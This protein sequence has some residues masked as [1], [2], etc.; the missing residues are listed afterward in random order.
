V[1]TP[2]LVD[3]NSIV[4]AAQGVDVH[5]DFVTVSRNEISVCHSGI[6]TMHGGRHVMIVNN[7]VDRAD[8]EG[9]YL[10]A[11]NA[12]HAEPA[13]EG[14]PAKPENTNHGCLVAKNIITDLGRG[15]EAWALWKPGVPGNSPVG[16][17]IAGISNGQLLRDDLV[18]SGNLIYDSGPDGLMED[19][20]V[21]FDR[22][23]HFKYAVWIEPEAAAQM[24]HLRFSGN[25]FPPGEL[26]VSNVE[27]NR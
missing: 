21:I 2:L 25:L 1:V 4:H 23:P 12:H 20:Q 27:L 26:G 7:L 13:R 14:K 3:G 11:G 17:K 19:G 16:I 9:I 10:G 8:D 24:K 6:K 5:A 15:L 22:Q 18:I